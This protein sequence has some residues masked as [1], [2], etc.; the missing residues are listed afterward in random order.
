MQYKGLTATN[1]YSRVERA[2]SPSRAIVFSDKSTE[3]Y[4]RTVPADKPAAIGLVLFR[5]PWAHV[6]SERKRRRRNPLDAFEHWRR[7]YF[8]ALRFARVRKR[9]VVDFDALVAD[10]PK[11]FPLV[12]RALGLPR[13]AL[14]PAD[15]QTIQWHHVGGSRAGRKTTVVDTALSS[16]GRIPTPKACLRV[17]GRLLE[18]SVI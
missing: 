16:V 13:P 18:A 3:V 4:A 15:L 10:P 11:A 9:V 17:Y 1:L 12:V 6:A 7:R 2:F 8:A 5:P 14:V